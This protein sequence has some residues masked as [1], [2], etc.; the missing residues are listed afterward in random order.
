MTKL[1]KGSGFEVHENHFGRGGQT[2]FECRSFFDFGGR[3]IEETE[4]G[5]LKGEEYFFLWSSDR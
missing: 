4:T 5:G 3:K 2:V 1:V